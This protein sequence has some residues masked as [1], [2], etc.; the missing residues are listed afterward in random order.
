MLI[1]EIC[2]DELVT[3]SDLHGLFIE[4][5]MI[6]QPTLPFKS[7]AIACQVSVFADD[8]VAGNDY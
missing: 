8:A 6:Q 4:S 2:G 1:R 5:F 7:A 3:D